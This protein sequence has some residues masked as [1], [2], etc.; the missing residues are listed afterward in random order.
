MTVDLAQVVF[1]ATETA[2]AE[3]ERRLGLA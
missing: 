1:Q 2:I 3:L